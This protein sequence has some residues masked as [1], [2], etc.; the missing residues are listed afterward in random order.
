MGDTLDFSTHARAAKEA[1]ASARERMLSGKYDIVILDEANVALHL[2]LI[3][4]EDVL[5]LIKEKPENVHLILSGR[6][7]HEEVI[8]HAHLVT[9]MRS[10]KHPF[11]LG[12]EAEKGIDY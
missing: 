9:E 11:D 3:G 10:I 5:S 12:I 1:L 7:A 6:H 4:L 8:R 2:K